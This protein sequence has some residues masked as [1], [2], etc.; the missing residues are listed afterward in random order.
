M[1]KIKKLA[2]EALSSACVVL[3]ALLSGCSSDE[4]DTNYY[5]TDAET[6]KIAA[7]SDVHLYDAQTL[8]SDSG[9]GTALAEYLSSDRKMLI[10]SEAILD[11]ALD[12][13]KT[14]G[15]DYLLISGDL[16][17][18]GEKVNH[19]L[20]ASKLA[21]V[22]EKGIQV[23]VIDGNHDISNS[24]AVKFSGS[25]TEKV[26]TVNTSDFKSIYNNFGYSEAVAVDSDSL[27]YAVNLGKN[28]R[29]IVMDSCKYNN[30]KENPS[31]ETSGE[32]TES[33]MSWIKAQ[34]SDAISA[35]KIPVGMMHH[36]LVEHIPDIQASIFS[37]YLEDNYKTTRETLSSAGMNLVFTGHFHS[38]DI[39]SA[40]V[41]GKKFYDVETGSLVTSPCPVRYVTLSGRN[42][43]C[44]TENVTSVP[45]LSLEHNGT[46][47][48][49]FAEFG[50]Q[51]LRTGMN[52]LFK[53]YLPSVLVKMGMATE[54]NSSAVTDTILET[55]VGSTTVSEML[56]DAF[57]AHYKGDEGESMNATTNG[58]I[59]SLLS[60][61]GTYASKA[62]S[63]TDATE[64]AQYKQQA[65]L[66]QT[67]YGV[68]YNLYN[69]SPTSDRDV[70]FAF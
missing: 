29:L 56:T 66:Y 4:G 11:A 23:F 42:F 32:I 19:E 18:D 31:Q 64:Q 13:I 39:A 7:I 65:A 67:L 21:E 34:I 55:T 63:A 27:S 10:Q 5:V 14:S 37:E 59:T 36:G 22:E 40:T 60:S 54:E 28:Y 26:E 1:K 30:D 9:E 45:N 25:T 51:F 15:V 57:V 44:K 3:L 6:V 16:T 50:E 49:T 69:D 17:K 20:L 68:T 24:D 58:L 43:T 47:Y 48:S 35:G 38:Q 62:S 52:D 2:V 70:S 8:G 33:R 46:T 12:S 61:Y 41:N 53:S